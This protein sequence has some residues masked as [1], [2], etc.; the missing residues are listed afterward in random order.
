M[1]SIRQLLETEVEILQTMSID[2]DRFLLEVNE[3]KQITST[4]IVVSNHLIQLETLIVYKE[5]NK[6]KIQQ[7]LY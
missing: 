5:Y 3:F 1:S 7:Y 6:K 2:K 4:F